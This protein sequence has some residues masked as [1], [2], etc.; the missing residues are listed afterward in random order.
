[1]W[2]RAESQ[3]PLRDT[4][5]VT[6]VSAFGKEYQ[7]LLHGV[8][9]KRR[10]GDHRHC[11]AFYV[12][13]LCEQFLFAHRFARAGRF[14]AENIPARSIVE[15]SIARLSRVPRFSKA[16]ACSLSCSSSLGSSLASKVSSG[17]KYRRIMHLAYEEIRTT[18]TAIGVIS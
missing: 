11:F 1:M 9:L 17:V 8:A 14:R 16:E 3:L 15:R 5:A 4:F 18:K 2:S 7:Y 10:I 13:K 12:R 6:C